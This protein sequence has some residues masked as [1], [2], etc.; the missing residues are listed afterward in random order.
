MPSAGQPGSAGTE[1]AELSDLVPE[2]QAEGEVS[3]SPAVPFQQH[4]KKRE[5][6]RNR[7]QHALS[8]PH[9][10]L[11]PSGQRDAAAGTEAPPALR[12]RRPAIRLGLQRPGLLLF[13]TLWL[14]L[15]VSA[16]LSCPH[17]GHCSQ[18]SEPRRSP[19][20]CPLRAVCALAVGTEVPV[21][22]KSARKRLPAGVSFLQYF[23][24]KWEDSPKCRDETSTR[25]SFDS[26]AGHTPSQPLTY[27]SS[28]FSHKMILLQQ[29]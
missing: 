19:C 3:G 24:W 9:V 13:R 11:L 4:K 2:N 25:P 6:S 23:I 10:R 20:K 17:R 29:S 18:H 1:D 5:C 12:T 28:R 14:L 15:P 16:Q 26:T 22:T 21:T 8:S 7:G 27:V